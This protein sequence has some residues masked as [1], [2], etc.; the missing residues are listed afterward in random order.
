[1]NSP[2]LIAVVAPVIAVCSA[3]FPNRNP[4]LTLFLVKPSSSP[5]LLLGGEFGLVRFKAFT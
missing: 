4:I 2:A 5:L 1:M 3:N